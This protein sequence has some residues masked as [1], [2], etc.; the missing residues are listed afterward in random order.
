[1]SQ[2][3]ALLKNV[4][5]VAF[6]VDGVMTDGRIFYDGQS[7]W[8]RFFH[9]H[10]GVGIRRLIM[11]GYEVAVITGSRAVDIQERCKGLGISHF[12][13]GAIDKIP[14]FE[15]FKARINA[16]ND[17]IAYIGDDYFDVPVLEQVAF[18]ATVPNAI[19]MV[20]SHVKYVTTSSGGQGAVRE[21]CDIILTHGRFQGKASH[22]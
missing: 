19:E 3:P 17:E 5:A 8:R 22:V 13:E 20:K 16:Q 4:R 11:S 12:Y 21:F 2:F 14:P 18:S 1:M 6:D 10:D 7:G 15:D 9:I